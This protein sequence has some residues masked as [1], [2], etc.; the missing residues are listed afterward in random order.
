MHLSL[1]NLGSNPNDTSG[2]KLRD[3]GTIINA[4]ITQVNTHS[5]SMSDQVVYIKQVSDFGTIDST[6]TYWIDGFIDMGSTSIEI[7]AA[8]ITIRGYSYRSSGLISS[9]AGATL[10]TSPVGGSGNVICKD[11]TVSYS[12][13]SASIFALDAAAGTEL[14]ELEGFNFSACTSLGFIDGYSQGVEAGTARIGGAP[15]LELRG[16][17]SGGYLIQR[18]LTRSLDPAMTEPLFKAGVGL[19]IGTRFK[20]NMAVALNAT[21]ALCDFSPANFTATSALQFE[22]MVVSRNG[23]FDVS[24]ATLIPNIDHGDLAA[25]WCNNIGIMNTFV[26]GTNT[27][28]GET[29]TTISTTGVYETLEAT[30]SVSGLQHFDSPAA[31]QLRHLGVNPIDFKVTADLTIDGGSGDNV[32]VRLMKFDS[33]LTSTSAI[34]LQRRVVNNFQGGRDVAFYTIQFSVMLNVNDYVYLEVANLTDTSD[35]TVELDSFMIVEER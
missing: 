26:G 5:D 30:W 7:P 28:S 23:V 15:S 17:W 10:F 19:V 20:S 22:D 27:V 9:T 34:G 12:G 31:G 3:G 25:S 35:V 8:G 2:D 29:T 13:T 21:A 14:I 6:K 18:S 24:D 33:V 1:I 16:T 32:S 11:L 4:A